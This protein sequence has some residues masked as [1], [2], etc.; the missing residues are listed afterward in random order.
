MQR[1]LRPSFF[2]QK[3]KRPSLLH[4]VTF[5]NLIRLVLLTHRLDN[6]E[7]CWSLAL[8]NVVGDDEVRTVVNGL[9]RTCAED[10]RWPQPIGVQRRWLVSTS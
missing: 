1:I 10:V 8:F 9:A 3:D 2:V 5:L 7:D 4:F 6:S